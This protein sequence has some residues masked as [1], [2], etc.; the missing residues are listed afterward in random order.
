MTAA[1]IEQLGDD[2]AGFA[3]GD[4]VVFP[5]G[6]AQTSVVPTSSLIGIPRD[7]SDRQAA[8]LLAPGLVARALLRQVYP[9]RS[10][11]RVHVSFSGETLRAV[12]EAWATHL[13]GIVVDDPATAHV[14]YDERARHAASV[15]A[16]HRRGRLQEAATDVFLA[17]RAGV[18][19]AVLPGAG[20]SLAAPV[21]A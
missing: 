9:L 21:A 3:R 1:T 20:R 13:G 18:F 5:L 19:D 8:D 12:T 17:M 15:Q 11:D 14:V 7:V 6:Y 2:T 10:G 16:G 4:R